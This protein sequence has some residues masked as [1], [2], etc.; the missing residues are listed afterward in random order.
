MAMCGNGLLFVATLLFVALC[1]YLWLY[2][3]ICSYV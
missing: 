2:A 3:A 1:S